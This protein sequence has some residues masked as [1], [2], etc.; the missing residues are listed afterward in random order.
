MPA[1]VRSRAEIS[2]SARIGRLLTPGAGFLPAA[3]AALILIAGLAAAWLLVGCGSGSSRR[4]GRE[5][6]LSAL[7]QPGAANGFNLLLVTLDTVRSD[8]LGCYGYA[9]A[10]TPT[11]D[12]LTERGLLFERAVTPVPITLPSHTTMLT[13]LYPPRH[14]ARDNGLYVVGEEQATMT[15]ALRE[16]GYETAAFVSCFVLDPRFGLDQGFETYDFR[17]T[18]MPWQA[19]GTPSTRRHAADATDAAISWIRGH[20]QRGSGKPFFLWVHYF[21]PHVPYDSPN[22]RLA[23]W[24]DR[25]YDGEIAYV[26]TEFRRL[27]AELDAKG[28]REKTLIALVS[29]HGE[30]LGEHGEATHGTFI[31]GSTIRVAFLLSCPGLFDGAYRCRDL[32][33]L[34]DLRPTLEDLLGLTVPAGLD[35]IALA[36]EDPAPDREV[37]LETV[38]PYHAARCSPLY[39]LQ[40]AG[41]KYVLGP[42]REY[43][44]LARDPNEVVNAIED[45]ATRVSA[46]DAELQ[47]RLRAFGATDL[48]AAASRELSPR[49]AEQLASLG[50]V[51]APAGASR[52]LPDPKAM[53]RADQE[54]KRA[55]QL[56][57]ENRPMEAL[58]ASRSAVEACPSFTDA[59]LLQSV[60]NEKMGRPDDAIRSLQGLL[61]LRESCEA[62]LSLARLYAQQRRFDEMEAALRRAAALEPDNGLV[63]LTRGDRYVLEGRLPEA[64]AEYERALALDEPRTGAVVRPQLQR[65]RQKL[66][67]GATAPR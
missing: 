9:Q 10:E 60:I 16:R 5:A 59:W 43:F 54:M 4:D 1:T 61:E 33:S 41:D 19:P 42:E 14:G 15:E 64:I 18:R 2:R 44:D 49:E 12:G 21:D 57:R 23:R 32:V 24:A 11:I 26:D 62:E 31:Y 67:G 27:L 22:S 58:A 56:L 66:G 46:L 65:L 25:L 45:N 17:T 63:H 39:G 28:L 7:L 13:G 3:P 8:H 55:F 36:R 38:M 50:Y 34:V 29:D 53:V 52:T 20:E 51:Q 6:S 40:S 47:S 37:Y 30:G 35:G 48:P